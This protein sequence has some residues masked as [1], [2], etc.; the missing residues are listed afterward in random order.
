MNARSP[1]KIAGR[2][3]HL[4]IYQDE[5][6]YSFEFYIKGKPH[7]FTIGN[8][9]PYPDWFKNRIQIELRQVS[10]TDLRLVKIS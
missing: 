8:N 4:H 1:Q 10:K 3:K 6:G 2:V 9:D 7:S 5:R